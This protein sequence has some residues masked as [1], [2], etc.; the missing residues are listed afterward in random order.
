MRSS[1]KILYITKT[2][3][4]IF[5]RCDRD[6]PDR[7]LALMAHY[8]CIYGN[9]YGVY[10]MANYECMDWWPYWQFWEKPK[11]KLLD[12]VVQIQY[13]GHVPI[14][15]TH[16]LAMHWHVSDSYIDRCHFMKLNGHNCGC[17]SASVSMSYY[18]SMIHFPPPIMSTYVRCHN[19]YNDDALW[20][21]IYTFILLSIPIWQ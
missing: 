2:I 5:V 10:L 4:Y 20:L 14:Q 9:L 17:A 18:I 16:A 13:T 8:K 3:Y 1:T 12:W 7:W 21:H 6:D 11:Q 15:L 19:W